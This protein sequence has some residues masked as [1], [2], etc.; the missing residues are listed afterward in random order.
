MV[1]KYNHKIDI[2]IS[3]YDTNFKKFNANYFLH[4]VI[5]EYYKK[6]YSILDL[7]G[8]TG[9]FSD[10]NPYKGLNRFKIGFNPTIYEFI[11]EYDLIL[12]PMTY[13]KLYNNGTLAK[14]LN[15]D[16]KKLLNEK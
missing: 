15:K 11:G 6:N 13:K 2:A 3:G 16:E 9:D 1:I 4:Y 8:L 14:V 5:I 10:N 7:N 12:K